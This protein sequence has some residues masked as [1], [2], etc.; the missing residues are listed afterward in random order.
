MP[1]VI[2]LAAKEQDPDTAL[3]RVSALLESICRR[4]SYLALLAEY[5]A[6]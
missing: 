4:A 3:L 5:P 1:L 2:T 6:A